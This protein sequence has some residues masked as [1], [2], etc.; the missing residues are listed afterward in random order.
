[1]SVSSRKITF[2]ALLICFLV[3]LFYSYDIFIRV[4]PSVMVNGLE[5]SFSIDSTSLGFLSA[6]YFYSYIVFQLPAGIILD[7]Y[8]CKWVISGAMFLCVLGNLLFSVSPNYEFAFLGRILMGIGSAFGFIG[9]A[10]VASIWLPS[11]FFS[12]FIGFTVFIGTMGGLIADTI[13]E[14]LVQDMGWRNGNNVFTA[15]GIIM[16]FLMLIFIKDSP[17][18]VSKIKHDRRELSLLAQSRVLL[19]IFKSYKFWIAGFIGAVLFIPINVLASLWGV[20]FIEAKLSVSEPVAAGLNSLLFIGSGVG[21]MIVSV[22][23]AY[24]RN[25]RAMLMIS[26]CILTGISILL[27]Y[28]P[29]PAWLFTT[30]FVLLGVSIGPQVLIFE[31]GKYLSPKGAAASATAGVNMINNIVAAILLPLFGFILIHVGG[32]DKISGHFSL[33][34]YYYAMS[35]LPLLT[36]VCIPLCLVFPKEI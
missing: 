9:A 25:Y 6:A 10:K 16:L 3:S 24:T 19:N 23:S 2:L 30:M 29:M 34:D 21:F 12:S 35:M 15:I 28:L 26:S 20:G 14:S 27:I 36:L 13:L 8:S 7:K 17:E 1:M 18:A 33:E 4:A 22:L 5:E 11:R 31:I 32:A